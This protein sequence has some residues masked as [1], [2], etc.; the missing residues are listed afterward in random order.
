MKSIRSPFSVVSFAVY[1]KATGA[2]RRSGRVHAKDIDAQPVAVDEGLI[3]GDFD[4]QTALC[5][6]E[7]G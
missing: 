6:P 3:E 4:F 2:I 7:W 5:R 1:D